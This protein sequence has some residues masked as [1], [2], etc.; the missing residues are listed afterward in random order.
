MVAKKKS[1]MVAY[2]K[3]TKLSMLYRVTLTP[4]TKI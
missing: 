3:K 1:Y 2:A 4:A